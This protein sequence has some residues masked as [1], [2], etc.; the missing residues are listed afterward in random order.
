MA[1]AAGGGGGVCLSTDYGKTWRPLAKG[2]GKGACMTVIVDPASPKDSRTLYACMHGGGVFKSTDGG[3]SW[4]AKNTGLNLEVNSHFTDLKRSRDGTLY[5]LCGAKRKERTSLAPGNL[6]KSTDGGETWTAL[7]EKLDLKL[8]YGFDVHPD[9]S[10][11]IYLSACAVPG[12]HDP[13]GIYRSADGGATW[14]KCRL[15]IPPDVPY[16][17]AAFPSIDP[18]NPRRVWCP[19]S[20]L[21]LMM[22]ADG[23]ETWRECKGLPFGPASRVTVDPQDHETIWVSTFG[24]GVW[25]GPA[26]GI[27]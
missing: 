24:G 11:V 19:V 16:I 1:D 18:Y 23:G 13:A 9:D 26:R 21:G 12:I 4:Q 10:K 27:E 14:K 6:F 5:A 25:R 17:N 3:Q 15:E 20:G 8:P 22:T 7:T 2:M